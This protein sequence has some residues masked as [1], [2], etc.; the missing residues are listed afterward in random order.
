M[1]ICKQTLAQTTL[2][3]AFVSLCGFPAAIYSQQNQTQDRAAEVIRIN[4]E[5]VQTEVMVFDRQGHFVEGL[6]PELFELMLNGIKQP[7]SFF[8]QVTAN[9][10]AEA[11]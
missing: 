6:K 4:T 2:A 8:E 10:Q 11:A 7:V 1:P 3:I 5:L 9:S